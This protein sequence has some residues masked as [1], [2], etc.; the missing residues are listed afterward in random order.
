LWTKNG[1]VDPLS[2]RKIF[3]VSSWKKLEFVFQGERGTFETSGPFFPTF[4]L[5]GRKKGLETYC[6][7]NWGGPILHVSVASV[8]EDV[9]LQMLE[10]QQLHSFGSAIVMKENGGPT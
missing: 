9:I 6:D 1:G 4:F 7:N 3:L 2:P 5:T 8:R 10:Q